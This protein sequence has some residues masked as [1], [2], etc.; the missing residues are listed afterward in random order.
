MV[1]FHVAIATQFL[2]HNP[3]R[4]IKVM[5]SRKQKATENPSHYLLA[6]VLLLVP[7]DRSDTVDQLDN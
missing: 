7:I 1:I 6:T 3:I 5:C 4:H 2:S